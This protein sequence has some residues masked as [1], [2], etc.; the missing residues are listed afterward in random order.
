MNSQNDFQA[1]NHYRIIWGIILVMA[2]LFCIPL[3]FHL[4]V[5]NLFGVKKID[6]GFLFISRLCYW[7]I[8]LITWMYVIKIEKQDF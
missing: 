1:L 8:L 2:L 4:I 5:Y 3:S 7:L 6:G